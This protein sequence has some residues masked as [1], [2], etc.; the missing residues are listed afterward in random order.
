MEEGNISPVD[1]ESATA[2]TTLIGMRGRP[3][4]LSP[5]SRSTPKSAT[6]PPRVV[7]MPEYG[8]EEDDEFA[9]D[10]PAGKQ[11]QKI[12]CLLPL[13]IIDTFFVYFLLLQLK[14]K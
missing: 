11:C 9:E 5:S 6:V 8:E 12:M 3:K 14:R 13:C 1:S 4:F 7:M 2:A 10:V